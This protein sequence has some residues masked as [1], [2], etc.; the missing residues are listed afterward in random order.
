MN[1]DIIKAD[2]SISLELI[3]DRHARPLLDLLNANRR[4]L[5]Q[6]LPWVDNMQTEADFQAYINRSKVQHD[7][8]TELG[9]VIFVNGL[10]AGRIGIHYI[11]QHNKHG[12]IGY[13]LG[14][15]FTGQGIIT[16]AC[17]A[18]I[19]YCFDSL[20]LNRI[21]IKCATENYKSAAIAKRLKF[22]KEGVLRQ[23]EFVNGE[24]LDL[25]LY[26]MLKNEWKSL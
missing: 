4:P 15:E 7:E 10:V 20:G 11:H 3:A 6:W 12:A 5:R 19:N 8:G 21:E 14:Q 16:K 17:I 25:D 2:A 22:T 1:S 13:W 24:F 18:L 26:S 23:V 9:Y